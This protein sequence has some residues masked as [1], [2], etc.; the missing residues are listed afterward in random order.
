MSSRRQLPAWPAR[1]AGLTLGALWL[2]LAMLGAGVLVVLWCAAALID[3]P[4]RLVLA[5]RRPSRPPRRRAATLDGEYTVVAVNGEKRAPSDS[6][7]AL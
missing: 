3:A 6:R 2:S 7:G 5:A 1:L 4:R